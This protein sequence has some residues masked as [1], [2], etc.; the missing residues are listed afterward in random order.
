MRL[1]VDYERE[2]KSIGTRETYEDWLYDT[3]GLHICEGCEGVTER[4]NGVWVDDK[5][6]CD[7]EC[8]E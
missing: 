6:Y 1:A 5:V 7:S 4:E 3:Y 2:Y 8:A